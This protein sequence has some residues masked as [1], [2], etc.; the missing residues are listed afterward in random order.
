MDQIRNLAE[1]SEEV[2]GVFIYEN[3][4][5]IPFNHWKKD[6]EWL[7]L[8][9]DLT[10]SQVYFVPIRALT[11]KEACAQAIHKYYQNFE[12]SDDI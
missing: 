2:G 3:I 11:A 12:V 10:D 7:I 4:E 5:A 1:Y 6:C 8:I 9:T